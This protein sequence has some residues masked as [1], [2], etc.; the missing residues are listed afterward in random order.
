MLVNVKQVQYT[1][2]CVKQALLYGVNRKVYELICWYTRTI[3]LSFSVKFALHLPLSVTSA[4]DCIK[5]RTSKECK[6]KL[7]YCGNT[8][9]RIAYLN[10][11]PCMNM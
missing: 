3:L 1:L 7:M 4:I 11:S 5:V 9:R 10:V 6:N 8:E 2:L